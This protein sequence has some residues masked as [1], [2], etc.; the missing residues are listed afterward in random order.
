MEG[1]VVEGYSV[2]VECCIIFLLGLDLVA[3][4]ASGSRVGECSGFVSLLD[5]TTLAGKGG[6]EGLICRPVQLG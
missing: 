4:R 3:S 5:N 2:C 1:N 6:G